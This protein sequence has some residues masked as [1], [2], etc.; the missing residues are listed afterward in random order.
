MLL[1]I[2]IAPRFADELKKTIHALDLVRQVHRSGC[3]VIVLQMIPVPICIVSYSQFHM[4]RL[5]KYLGY[6]MYSVYR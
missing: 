3:R 1:T 5:S 4:E 6:E 2:S